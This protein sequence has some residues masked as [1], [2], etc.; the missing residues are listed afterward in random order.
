MTERPFSQVYDA[1]QVRLAQLGQRLQAERRDSLPYLHTVR[2]IN[3]LLFGLETVAQL[4]AGPAQNMVAGY[5]IETYGLGAVATDPF[6]R[7]L[8][9][10][11]PAAGAAVRLRVRAANGNA[12][13]A[14]GAYISAGAVLTPATSI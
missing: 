4:P 1:A 5:L 9:P 12:V 6:L 7:P 10:P 3:N 11:I 8:L 13:F 2:A 14:N